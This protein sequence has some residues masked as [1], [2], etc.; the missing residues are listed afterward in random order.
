METYG[1]SYTAENPGKS[2]VMSAAAGRKGTEGYTAQ[3]VGSV[4]YQGSGMAPHVP[5]HP[6]GPEGSAEG[7]SCGCG[8]ESGAKTVL[9]QPE[10]GG[11]MNNRE[12]YSQPQPGGGMYAQG[13][14]G[15]PQPGGG[16]YTQGV[17]GQPQPGGGMYA[18]GV[19]GQPQ[20]GGGMYV[21]GVYGQPQMFGSL[22]AQNQQSSYSQQTGPSGDMNR[23]GQYLGVINDVASG[24]T[25][26]LPEIAQMVQQA[27][28][29]F[30]K[31]AIV[32]AVAGLLLTSESVRGGLG[33][34]MGAVF[35]GFGGGEK[36]AEAE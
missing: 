11:D 4:Q 1:G 36:D 14:Y 30:W 7:E 16:M 28:G 10:M 25:P 23:F 2:A 6:S 5:L 27:P 19:Y 32:G 8:D 9:S 3:G 29:D 21:Q 13:V 22:N 26:E 24:R 33:S 18:Q 31:G 17:F 12:G 15:Q 35:S 20:P 34:V